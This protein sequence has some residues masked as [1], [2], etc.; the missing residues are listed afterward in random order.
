MKKFNKR[1]LSLMIIMSMLLSPLPAIAD[2]PEVQKASSTVNATSESDFE[3]DSAKGEITGYKGNEKDLVIPSK[4]D[5]K[6]VYGLG[7]SALNEKGLTSVVLPEGMTY[8]KWGALGKND[9]TSVKMP[10][11]M[12]R[13]EA[14]AFVLNKQLKHVELNK[15]LKSI[16]TFAFSNLPSL[17]GEMDIPS[18]V[19]WIGP[20]AFFKSNLITLNIKGDENSAPIVLKNALSDH[21]NYINLENERKDITIDYTAF[22]NREVKDKVTVT[23]PV[24]KINITASSVKEVD[25]WI[26]NN[27]NI[28]YATYYVKASDNSGHSDIKNPVDIKWDTKEKFVKDGEFEVTGVMDKDSIRDLPSKDGYMLANPDN[29]Q[30]SNTISLKFVVT[31]PAETK[32]EYEFDSQKGVIT[33]YLGNKTE[34]VIPDEIDGVKVKGIASGAFRNK[35]LTS[36]TLPKNLEFTEFGSFTNNNFS[37]IVFPDTMKSIGSYSFNNNKN[38][39][40]VVFNEGLKEIGN[41]AFINDKVLSGNLVIPSTVEWIGPSAFRYTN[42]NK[43]KIKGGKDSAKLTL[44]NNLG[45]EIKEFELEDIQKQLYVDFTSFCNNPKTNLITTEK[46]TDVGV[47]SPEELEKWIK[48]NVN[49]QFMSS[50]QK[51]GEGSTAELQKFKTGKYD[52]Y[53]NID[54]VWEPIADFKDNKAIAKAKMQEITDETFPQKPGFIMNKV[55]NY[56]GINTL[57]FAFNIVDKPKEDDSKFVASDFTYEGSTV[58]GFSETGLKKIETI[59]DVNLPEKSSEGTVITSIGNAAFKQKGMKSVSIPE[60]VKSIGNLAFQMNELTEIKLPSKLETAGAASFATNKI[61]EVTIPGTL[62]E[63]PSGMFSTNISTKIVIENGV[64]KI[65]QSAFTGCKIESLTLPASVKSVRRMAFSGGAKEQTGKL[66]ELILNEGLEKIDTKAFQNNILKEVKIPVSLNSI[67]DDSFKGNA[68]VVEL[69]TTNEDHLKFNTEKSLKNQKFVLV[70]DNSKFIDSDF[71]YDG[72]KITGFSEEGLKKLET[73]KNVELPEKSS[74]GTAITTIGKAAFRNKGIE[75]VTI[76]ETVTTI[77]DFAFNNNKLTEINLGKNLKKLGTS[78]FGVNQITK[79]TIPANIGE[80]PGGLFTMNPITELTI[81]DGI[82]K[83]GQSAFVGNELTELTIPKSVESI[84]RMAF[85]SGNR[86]AKTGTLKK[87]TLNEGLKEIDSKAFV[88]NILE[89]VNVPSSLEK[90]ADDSFQGNV[91]KDQKDVVF[92][93]TKKQDHLKLNNEKSIKN[94]KFIFT[95]KPVKEEFTQED[96]TYKQNVI[97]GFSN[98]GMAKFAINKDV[99]LPDKS[100]DGTVITEIGEKAF[101]IDFDSLEIIRGCLPG[102]SDSPEGIKTIKLPSKLEKIGR[103]AFRYNALNE[104]DYPNTLKSIDALAFSGNQL[105]SVSLPDSV[106][107]LGVGV[108]SLNKIETVKLSNSLTEI[109]EGMFSYNEIKKLELNE[110]I[111]KVGK[112]AF[113]GNLLEELKLPDSLVTIETKGF[114]A[115]LLKEIIIP[116][117]VK[118][119]GKDAFKQKEKHRFITKVVLPEG[120][121][122]IGVEAFS[123]NNLVE[124]NLPKSLT[125]IADNAFKNILDLNNPDAQ[126]RVVKLFTKNPDHLKFNNEKS[127]VNQKVIYNGIGEI[128]PVP[129]I[130]AEDIEK[131]VVKQGEKIDVSDNIKNLPEKATVKD[132]TEPKIDTN[133]PGEYTAKVEVTFANG[134]KRIVEI[135]VVVEKKETTPSEPETPEEIK[136]TDTLKEIFE[137][138]PSTRIAGRNRQLTAVEVSKA[139]FQKADTVIITSS[140]KMVDSLAS[141]PYGVGIKA[142]TLLVDKDSISKEILSEIKRLNPSKIIIAG[143]K[144]SISEKVENQI[145]QLGIKQQRIAGADRFETAVKLG[146]Q[147]RANSDNKKEIILVN[148]FNNIDA[149]TAGSLAAKLNIPVL[150]T[151]SDQLNKDTEK[152]IKDWG[153]EKVTIIGGKTQVSEAIKVKLQESK[154]TVERLA[155]RTR[156]DTALEVAKA[157]NSD[158]DKV[159]FANKTAYP[160]ALIAP[161]LSKTEQAPIMLIDKDEASVSVKQYLRDNKIKD[162][163]ILGGKLSIEEYK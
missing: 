48:D 58:T 134:S 71:T 6:Q 150:L 148:G 11:T 135:P 2:K 128:E 41:H 154:I 63:I 137:K 90:I 20:K 19:E 115:N 151:D 42:V 140:D 12:R 4:I 3:F 105:H 29:C 68:Q 70:E 102:I 17:S 99:V 32:K 126:V 84:G 35:N 162:S 44:K 158:P 64:E 51:A 23:A 43:F 78:V 116:K 62:K 54:T 87:L 155:G 119:I 5:G 60:T 130:K 46:P 118:T 139:L 77:E 160:D 30:G 111:K 144:L 86:Y 109:N 13:I 104:V 94:Q 22:C 163:I 40:E 57:E 88:N 98:S 52:E 136:D 34:L 39:R 49:I 133:K 61:K 83:I 159:I 127:L 69:Q 125:S 28:Q 149:L 9:L 79:V 45:Q 97:T 10:S 161:Y 157:V 38:L 82:K 156:V 145:K 15:G 56:G 31:S 25:D 47:S 26:K 73:S 74:D 107:D 75:S 18:T 85:K 120:L 113:R 7:K 92:L 27:I 96:F 24:N 153:I 93:Y 50:Y 66:K 80:I 131:E 1:F 59:K 114:Q 65:G 121:E 53:V 152:A 21:L 67:K 33:K 138:I 147:V 14:Y 106:T 123:N 110:G 36:V 89:E 81:E 101:I 124:V 37:K 72:S 132:I 141:S 91:G 143:G 16:E 117:N 95:G 146:E 55:S 112:S 76:S 100:P 129:E 103:E 122:S 142:P 8:L 108:F